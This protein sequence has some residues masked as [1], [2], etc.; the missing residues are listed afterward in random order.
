MSKVGSGRGG[1]LGS[2]ETAMPL[3]SQLGSHPHDSCGKG[4]VI[5]T[6][7]LLASYYRCPIDVLRFL[8]GPKP[9]EREGFFRF[10]PGATCYGRLSSAQGARSPEEELHDALADV[11]I[12]AAGVRLPFDAF[13]II[14]NLRHER[15]SAH[16]REEGSALNNLVR[17]VYYFL[18]PLLTVT[19][20][21]HLQR[22]RL[23]DW[24]GIPFPAWP[25]DSTVDLIHKRLL[26][27]LLK[28]HGLDMVPFIWFWPEDFSCCAI[29]T[30]DVEDESG[31]DFCSKLMDLD[32][33]YGIKSAF[34]VVPENRY[35]V[36]KGFLDSIKSRGFEVN[37]HDLKHDGRLYADHSEFLR[38]ASRINEY[39]REFGAEGFRSGILYR[40]AD[41]F[42]AFDFSYDMSIPNVGH[43]D[44]QRGGCCTVMPF[45]I[46]NIVELPVTCTQDYTLFHILDDY[47]I[48]LWRMQIARIQEEHGIISIIVHPDYVIDQRARGT[49][50]AL[51]DHLAQLKKG[52]DVWAALPK[53]VANWW[54]QRS[55][56][57]LVNQNGSWRV[58]GPG[59]ERARLAYASLSGDTVTYSLQH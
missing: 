30:H 24:N 9:S 26:A 38:R 51:L 41:W 29:L 23:R 28:A 56:L 32:E 55:Q 35:T 3:D 11:M 46:G 40:N 31:R 44:P 4:S 53:D 25:L 54:R 5:S 42:E 36:S 7:R 8:P 18:R 43:L 6:D 22:I 49:Y 57:K 27:L 13:E 15:Y 2:T 47:S 37:V 14:Q 21:R 39:I 52:G 17:K 16:F 1:G 12:D 48:D 34:Q 45:F 50:Q 10:G 19:I 33:S 58:E 20:R 59:Y